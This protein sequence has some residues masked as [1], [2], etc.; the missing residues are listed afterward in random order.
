[1]LHSAVLWL[2]K[3]YCLLDLRVS[4]MLTAK[5][6]HVRISS[7]LSCTRCLI[8][9]HFSRFSRR[10]WCLVNHAVVVGGDQSGGADELVVLVVAEA[11]F[12][13]GGEGHVVVLQNGQAILLLLLLH[14][15]HFPQLLQV[16]QLAEGLQHHQ[17]DDQTQEQVHWGDGR[18]HRWRK[19]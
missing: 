19:G 16:L 2:I 6:W 1:M 18:T 13:H 8:L 15:K 11:S 14:V 12:G 17:H 3:G 7:W 9:S 5:I 10:R 4:S